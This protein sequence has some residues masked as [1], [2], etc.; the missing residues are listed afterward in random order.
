MKVTLRMRR[1]I[2]F[3]A[4]FVPFAVLWP[5]YGALTAFGIGLGVMI[6]AVV[7]DRYLWRNRRERYDS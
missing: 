2:T 6:V 3:L 7:L 5:I 4:G 1:I